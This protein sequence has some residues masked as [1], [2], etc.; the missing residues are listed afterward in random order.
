METRKIA[1]SYMEENTYASV[2][3]KVNSI[4]QYN[5]YIAMK[6]ETDP[7]RTKKL[8]KVSGA[9]EKTTC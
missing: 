1:G 3:R 6:K 8:A 5:K 9:P 7:I 4:N 2:A